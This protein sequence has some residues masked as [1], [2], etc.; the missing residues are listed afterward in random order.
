MQPEATSTAGII[1]AVT[2][3]GAAGGGGEA[4]PVAGEMATAAMAAVGAE[5]LVRC[6]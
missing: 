2:R 5:A 3:T 4:N 1:T 6:W